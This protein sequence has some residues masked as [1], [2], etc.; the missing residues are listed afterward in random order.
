MTSLIISPRTEKNLRDEN[1]DAFG[2][3]DTP[4]GS[5]L[6]VCDGMGGGKAGHEA[7]DYTCSR[8]PQLLNQFAEEGCHPKEALTRAVQE[9]NARI[10]ELATS[11]NP[12]Y[13]RMGT[14]LCFALETP[15]GFIIG[16]VGDSRVYHHHHGHLLALTADHAP[17]SEMVKMGLITAEQGLTHPRRSIL[18][19]AIGAA[20]DTELELRESHVTLSP[21]DS[22]LLCSDGLTGFTLDPDIESALNKITNPREASE[23]LLK[24][25]LDRG[26][27]D[28]IT[29]LMA[30][31]EGPLPAAIARSQ[32]QVDRPL[33]LGSVAV[34]RQTLQSGARVRD[35]ITPPQA[36]EAQGEAP[37]IR[38]SVAK[39]T[40][41]EAHAKGTPTDK[42][43]RTRPG[44][45]LTAKVP[46]PSSNKRAWAF[47]LLLLLLLSL[48]TAAHYLTF[49]QIEPY[50]GGSIADAA[51][52][53]EEAP[54]E[55]TEVERLADYDWIA[56]DCPISFTESAK[57]ML[58]SFD[59]E[60]RKSSQTTLQREM[61]LGQKYAEAF[62]KLYPGKVDTDT[63]WVDYLDDLSEVLRPHLE[64]PDMVYHI[65]YV[66]DPMENAFALPGGHVYIFRGLLE[67]H[68][69]SEAQLVFV[70]AH[71]MAHVDARHAL[72][73]ERFLEKVPSEV[74]DKTGGLIQ[75][76]L[77]HPFSMTHEEEADFLAIKVMLKVDYAATQ[78]VLFLE[79]L[80]Q[81]QAADHT[82]PSDHPGFNPLEFITTEL[83]DLLS[84]HPN[85]TRRVCQVRNQVIFLLNQNAEDKPRY[86]GETNFKQRTPRS[87]IV[88]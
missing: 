82:P 61:E 40:V 36:T 86:V 23:A 84:T 70:L 9:I 33:P 59:E 13:S 51:L 75:F 24:L 49:F 15:G 68:V 12:A 48:A 39:P 67:N 72:A 47:L 3:F 29:I 22:L 31:R 73:F 87:Q 26:S 46:P 60:L 64:R 30:H 56:G 76:M 42:P 2:H 18:S 54:V 14:T 1:Q 57:S 25:A 69:R 41:A 5:L 45:T 81:I 78:S 66:D 55:P 50:D 8:L 52:A 44:S 28:N 37:Q 88:Y 77:R 79:S 85:M 74:R 62:E 17:V 53:D 58:T 43:S 27:D 63:D 16:H 21:G 20:I 7:A 19:R 32:Q 38:P 80:G 71:E 34:P 83:S 4:F 11:G 65:H 10:Y 35:H 6:V